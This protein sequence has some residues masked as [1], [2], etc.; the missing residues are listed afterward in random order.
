MEYHPGQHQLESVQEHQHQQQQPRDE[1]IIHPYNLVRARSS[2]CVLSG[3]FKR[4]ENENGA[5]R[6]ALRA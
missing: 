3:T 4:K 2:H 5:D 1:M 6:K